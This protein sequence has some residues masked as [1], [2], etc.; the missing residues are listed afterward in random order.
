MKSR[1]FLTI[2]LL[3]VAVPVAFLTSCSGDKSAK[4]DPGAN[5]KFRYEVAMTGVV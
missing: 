5:A 3:A 1:S 2:L 4:A